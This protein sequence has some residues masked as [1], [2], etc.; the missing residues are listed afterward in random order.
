M[1]VLDKPL[2]HIAME[3]R[4][5]AAQLGVTQLTPGMGLT[6]RVRATTF[7]REMTMTLGAAPQGSGKVDTGRPVKAVLS[8]K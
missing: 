7:Y 5:P 4:L 2:P 6:M 3:M 1:Q 8:D